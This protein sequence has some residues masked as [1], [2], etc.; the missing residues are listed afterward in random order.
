MQVYERLLRLKDV[1]QVYQISGISADEGYK[2]AR[3]AKSIWHEAENAPNPEILSYA[4]ENTMEPEISSIIFDQL[5][6]E[7]QYSGRIE[8]IMPTKKSL[9]RIGVRV[10]ETDIVPVPL[11]L[12]GTSMHFKSNL[13]QQMIRNLS[14]VSLCFVT[15]IQHLA[16]SQVST[17]YDDMVSEQRHLKTIESSKYSLIHR[18]VNTSNT[19]KKP[20]CNW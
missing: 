12:E 15:G 4:N 11:S 1:D 3:L 13:D 10:Y 2:K 9:D 7:L 6:P 5:F 20:E 17:D 14:E 8:P 16:L 19:N 18:F